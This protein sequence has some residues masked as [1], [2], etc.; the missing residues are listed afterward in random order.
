MFRNGSAK[1]ASACQKI[2]E[3]VDKYL[4]THKLEDLSDDEDETEEISEELLGEFI[5]YFTNDDHFISWIFAI[6]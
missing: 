3:G 1:F 4:E 5:K 6:F 2:Q